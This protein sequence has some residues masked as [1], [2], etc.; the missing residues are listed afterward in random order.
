MIVGFLL[1]DVGA[2]REYVVDPIDLR[3]RGYAAGDG[4]C[5]IV[6]EFR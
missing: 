2:I 6:G 1:G 5:I 4:W 3:W